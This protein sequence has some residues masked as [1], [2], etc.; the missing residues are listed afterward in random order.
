MSMASFICC[1]I[2][3]TYMNISMAMPAELALPRRVLTNGHPTCIGTPCYDLPVHMYIIPSQVRQT[4][5]A[6][7]DF[8]RVIGFVHLSLWECWH[9][10]NTL[11]PLCKQ[12]QG[13]IGR[14][15]QYPRSH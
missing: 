10:E 4:V 13:D 3:N 11:C 9:V 2:H 6:Y 12:P 14:E 7:C 8:D 5:S 1:C 15:A